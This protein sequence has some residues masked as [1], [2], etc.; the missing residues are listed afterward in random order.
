MREGFL[1]L[2]GTSVHDMGGDARLHIDQGDVV[3]DDVVEVT[4]DPQ[5]LLG[6]PAAGLLLAGALGALGPLPYRVDE[7]TAAAYGISRGPC[8]AGPG[9]DAEVLLRVPGGRA[10]EHCGAG[11]HGHGQQADPPRGGPVGAG[12]D[13]V[14]RD[15]GAH[16][17][18]GG[19]IARDQLDDGD[20]GGEHEHGHRAAPAED[21]GAGDQDHQH[22][23]AQF[24]GS[25][26]ELRPV[27]SVR[28]GEGTDE[29]AEQYRHGQRAV[30]RQRMRAEP[31]LGAGEPGGE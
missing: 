13:G 24:G 30:E 8:H 19:R 12:G 26:P 15:H 14:E 17:D 1:G 10:E 18:R 22:H 16:R 28:V 21:E 29:H 9:E 31:A 23:T 25:A 5:P 6:D 11:Q 3:R 4:G 27:P 2:V 20:R 7:G